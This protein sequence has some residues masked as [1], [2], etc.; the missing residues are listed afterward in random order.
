MRRYR[1]EWVVSL[2]MGCGTGAPHSLLDSAIMST[3]WGNQAT[4]AATWTW[5]SPIWRR[6]YAVATSVGG[7]CK[8][9]H[10]NIQVR[11]PNI[12]I[13][14]THSLWASLSVWRSCDVICL[15]APLQLFQ[16]D[17]HTCLVVQVYN[18]TFSTWE[19]W[20]CSGSWLEWIESRCNK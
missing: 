14:T 1:L 2:V 16:I 4:V 10:C 5:T 3:L 20:F 8:R 19:I 13:M 12:Q 11:Q 7:T 18:I 6:N 15:R 9:S 17:A